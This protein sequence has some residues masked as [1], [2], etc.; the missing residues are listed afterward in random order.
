MTEAP[1]LTLRGIDITMGGLEASAWRR[2]SGHLDFICELRERP[3]GPGAFRGG[4]ETPSED[5]GGDAAAAW[6]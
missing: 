3:R 1:T 5:R 2:A 6:G 4:R